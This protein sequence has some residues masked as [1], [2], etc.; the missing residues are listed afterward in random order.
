MNEQENED[1]ESQIQGD[2]S[3][4]ECFDNQ[5]PDHLAINAN[6]NQNLGGPITAHNHP[7]GISDDDLCES[8]RSLN[9]Q[10][11]NAFD[12]VLSWCR[13]KL[14]NMNTL[15]PVQVE[16]IYLFITGGAGAGKSHLIK[17]IYHTATKNFMHTTMN[18]ELPVVLLMAPTGVAA[19]NINGTTI[20]SALAIPKESSDNLSPMS[21]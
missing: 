17:A 11:R 9:T 2:S 20:H 14:K 1:L 7:L 21:D 3:E 12:I 15:K 10:Q 8:V 18:P 16:P 5:S 6:S 4:S 13:N 19:I